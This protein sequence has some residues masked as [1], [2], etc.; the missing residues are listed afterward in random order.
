MNM[1]AITGLLPGLILVA[2]MAPASANEE[3][4]RCNAE[5][6]QIIIG[7]TFSTELGE[8]ARSLSGARA[9]VVNH[10]LTDFR[11]DRLQIGINRNNIINDVHCG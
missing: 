11:A 6:A 7:Q 8:H 2:T 9:V 10:V 4:T 5:P 1:N 3:S